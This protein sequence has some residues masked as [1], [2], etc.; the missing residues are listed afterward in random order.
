MQT[1]CDSCTVWRTRLC[2]Q[3]GY[4]PAAYFPIQH[5]VAL[6]ELAFI[7]K[8]AARG[9]IQQKVERGGLSWTSVGKTLRISRQAARKRFG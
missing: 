7:A 8:H 5:A 2:E 6:E 3:R 4:S 1:S 9:T